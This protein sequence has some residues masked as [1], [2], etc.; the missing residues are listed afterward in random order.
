[1][2]RF[3]LISI[4]SP[5]I[6]INS[7]SVLILTANNCVSCKSDTQNIAKTIFLSFIYIFLQDSNTCSRI[8]EV[9]TSTE[10]SQPKNCPCII[11][12]TSSVERPTCRI[13]VQ[14]R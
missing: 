3:I 2:T 10:Y 11:G 5:F 8:C 13:D 4:L 14:K 12:T 7:S 6:I 1:M 9:R